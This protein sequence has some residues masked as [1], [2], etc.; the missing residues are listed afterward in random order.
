MPELLL[1]AFLTTFPVLLFSPPCNLL[2]IDSSSRIRCGRQMAN[3]VGV[4]FMV[5]ACLE[6]ASKENVLK[7]L[8]RMWNILLSNLDISSIRLLKLLLIVSGSLLLFVITL[9]SR[10]SLKNITLLNW[11]RYNCQTTVHIFRNNI[12][13]STANRREDKITRWIA[14]E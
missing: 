3:V 13:I 6:Y 1:R 4:S 2:R 9:I 10:I 14:A 12:H 8:Q 11:S 7:A 5:C